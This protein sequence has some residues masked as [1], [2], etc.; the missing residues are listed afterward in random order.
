MCGGP[1]RSPKARDRG[2]LSLGW[3]IHRD[4]GHLPGELFSQLPHHSS[5]T[6]NAAH[7]EIQG[8]WGTQI[9]LPC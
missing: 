2:T 8:T 5:F 9:Q 7:L 6:E 4:R 3:E 1:P